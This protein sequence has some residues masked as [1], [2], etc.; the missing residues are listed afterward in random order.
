[1]RTRLGTSGLAALV[2]V[3][4]TACASSGAE[5][6]GGHAVSTRASAS[7]S[8][9]TATATGSGGGGGGSSVAGTAARKP[10]QLSGCN[11]D[12]AAYEVCFSSPATHG[13]S[14]PAV[15]R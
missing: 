2:L 14:D 3:V 7:T 15:V 13:G 12:G 1:M 11:T 10:T 9:A 4:S 5:E 8:T 6:P